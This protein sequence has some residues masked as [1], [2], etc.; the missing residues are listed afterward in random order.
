MLRHLQKPNW[1]LLSKLLIFMLYSN[2]T[3][4]I[5]DEYRVPLFLFTLV[6]E[7]NDFRLLPSYRMYT[8]IQSVNCSNGLLLGIMSYY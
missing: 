2:I 1:E 8:I 4:Y 3:G 7:F 5:P 6:E